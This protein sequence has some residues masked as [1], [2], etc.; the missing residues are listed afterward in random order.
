MNSSIYTFN[1][2]ELRSRQAPGGPRGSN[3]GS[4]GVL[5]GGDVVEGSNQN[6]SKMSGSIKSSNPANNNN[7]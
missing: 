6:T 5:N 1:N 3:P 4:K 2:I 7:K